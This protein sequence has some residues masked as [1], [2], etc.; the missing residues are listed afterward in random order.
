M[1]LSGTP[2]RPCILILSGIFRLMERALEWRSWV[3][4]PIVEVRHLVNFVREP[5]FIEHWDLV[6]D[7]HVLTCS[8]LTT[9]L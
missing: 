6:A 1:F 9:P 8:V 2:V 4:V 5:P 7:F 3:P